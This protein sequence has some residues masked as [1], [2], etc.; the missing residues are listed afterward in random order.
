VIVYF[1]LGLYALVKMIHIRCFSFNTSRSITDMV[2]QEHQAAELQGIATTFL[3]RNCVTIGSTFFTVFGIAFMRNSLRPFHCL[4]NSIDASRTFMATSPDIDCSID[5]NGQYRDERYAQIRYIAEWSLVGYMFLWGLISGSLA[6]AGES[7]NPGLGLLGFMGDKYEKQYFYWEMVIVGRKLGLMLSF[8]L[9]T[10]VFAWLLGSAVL[11][12]A[13][14]LQAWTQPYDDK[15]TDRAEFLTLIANLLVF[16][17]GPL[18]KI[19]ELG[20]EQI[21]DTTTTMRAVVEATAVTVMFAAVAYT[22]AAERHVL[23]ATSGKLD[24]KEELIESHLEEAREKLQALQRRK[25]E[26]LETHQLLR[27]EER[28]GK[29]AGLGVHTHHSKGGNS[30]QFANPLFSSGGTTSSDSRESPAG[31]IYEGCFVHLHTGLHSIPL[32]VHPSTH[33]PAVFTWMEEIEHFSAEVIQIMHIGGEKKGKRKRQRREWARIRFDDEITGDIHVGWTETFHARTLKKFIE[34]FNQAEL[35]VAR[36]M[37][38]ADL[39]RIIYLSGIKDALEDETRLVH[40]YS[41]YGTVLA[42][43]LRRKR[44][45]TADGH[46]HFSWALISFAKAESAEAAIAGTPNVAMEIG[47]NDLQARKVDMEK[48]HI[49][50]GAMQDVS[51]GVNALKVGRLE[52][53]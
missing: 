22:A 27:E 2:G 6:F 23:K 17:T 25:L 1:T 7:K 11:I 53:E 8:L 16:Q 41:A 9:N 15:F 40:T 31:M 19:L 29:Q 48:V 35:D 52:R 32:R 18:F 24:Y 14:T 26:L 13:A 34:P 3:L 39:D 47:N 45:K 42:A 37:V 28:I 33:S 10:S 46:L 12:T 36:E 30:A 5:S 44:H 38:G 20:D 51:R 4:A 43:S 49:S 50:S 21:S